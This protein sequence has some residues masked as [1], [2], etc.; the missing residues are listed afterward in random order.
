MERVQINLE[1]LFKASPKILYQFLTAPDCLIRWFCDEVEI[2]GDSYIFGWQGTEETAE[3]I[4]SEEEA[5]LKFQW[6]EA[7]ENEFLEYRI[8]KGQV[9]GQTTLVISDYC[10]EDEIDDQ[11]SLWESQMKSLRH[12]MGG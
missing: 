8:S 6:E 2:D 3:L 4:D 12:A 11:K 10:D 1:Y 7:E 9:T 5:F